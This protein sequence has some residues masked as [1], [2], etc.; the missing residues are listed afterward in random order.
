MVGEVGSL[1]SATLRSRCLLHIQGEAGS[2]SCRPEVQEWGL[3]TM[4]MSL[5]GAPG[6]RGF[7]TVGCVLLQ[8]VNAP[9]EKLGRLSP[10]RPS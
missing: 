3:D 4:Q 5:Q 2:G 7:T 9:R 8:E 6:Y 10:G 1:G